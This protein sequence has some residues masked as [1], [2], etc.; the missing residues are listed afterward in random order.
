VIDVRLLQPRNADPLS[1]VTLAGIEIVVAEIELKAFAA[2]VFTGKPPRVDGTVSVPET[3]AVCSIV[4]VVP[5][6]V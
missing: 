6:V 3:F 5:S 4:A 1:E 2:M